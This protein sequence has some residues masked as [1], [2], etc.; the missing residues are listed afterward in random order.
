MPPIRSVQSLL[1][2]LVDFAL[3]PRCPA[4]GTVVV[5][6]DS[7]CVACWSGLH[8]LGSPCC[9]CCGAPFPHDRGAGALCGACLATLP[10]I[11]R[12]RA[13]LAYGP[14]ARTLALRLKYGRR[15]GLARLMAAQIARQMPEGDRSAMLLM[16]VPLHRWRLWWRGF[17]QAALIADRIGTQTGVAVDKETLV[18]IRR[19]PPLRGMGP[20]AR[21]DAVRSAFAVRPERRE[22]LK[23]RTILLIDDVH[24]TGATAEACTKALLRA[25]AAEVQLLCWARVLPDENG[26]AG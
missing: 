3:P 22:C 26:T 8:F 18:R 16:P 7:F 21:R 14:V 11:T 9:A 6:D 12:A 15:T 17:N 19:T 1:R 25:G 20:K 10:A 24:T 23:D 13:A 2:P 4:C 5:D